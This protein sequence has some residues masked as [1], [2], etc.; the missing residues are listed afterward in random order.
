[1][2]KT[3]H[4]RRGPE[5]PVDAQ[6]APLLREIWDAGIDTLECSPEARP[7][8]AG[9]TFPGT[10][11]LEDFLRLADTPCAF[12]LETAE[13]GCPDCGH[14]V[15]R[16]RLVVY[17]PINDIPALVRA[18]KAHNARAQEDWDEEEEEEG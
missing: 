17:F 2:S 9:I 12:H 18:F 10:A 8:E 11:D 14:P 3:V 16:V 5:V 6:L 1:M 7:G 13:D 15:T 4:L